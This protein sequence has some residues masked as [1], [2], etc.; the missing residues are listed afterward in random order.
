MITLFDDQ[1]TSIKRLRQSLRYFKHVVLQGETGSGKSVMAAYMIANSREKGLISLFI[2]PRKDLLHQMSETFNDFDIS[3]SFIAQGRDFNPFSKTF[4]CTIGTLVN[5]LDKVRPDIVFIDECHF[6]A[7]Q[8]EKVI[9]YY[10][11][12]GC[13]I[14]GLTASPEKSSGQGLDEYYGDMVVG[15]SIKELIKLK[16]LSDYKLF[17]P[18]TPDLS[19]IKTVA[20]DYA[21]GEISSF[22]EQESILIGNAVKHYSQHA[23]GKLNI[24][25]CTSIKH[26]HITADAFC[27]AGIPAMHIDGETPDVE[28]RRIARMFAQRELLVLCS[29]DLMT[30]GYDLAS[31]SGVRNV[32]IESMSDL[33][34]TK[35]RPLQRQ[36]NGR[37]LR[38]KDF[39]ATI[40]DH[41]GNNT[42]FGY[43]DDDISWS[44]KG[45][46]KGSY[47]TERPTPVKQCSNC[48][49]CHPPAPQCPNCGLVYPV[50]SRIVDEIEGTL[51][52]IDRDAMRVKQEK[53]D[54]SDLY[55]LIAIA[56][57]KGIA[58]PE[59]WA[60][61]IQS[62]NI[63][64][65]RNI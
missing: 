49:F 7:G 10:K 32:T 1:F 28:R 31:A 38:Y 54:R 3:H 5:R 29:V 43:P 59:R 6:G 36:K 27:K 15:P 30:F 2:V 23:M 45:R 42:R 65:R 21:R 55:A 8:L 53:K 37:V 12:L 48:F 33:R 24:A 35:S 13:W 50:K 18:Y 61:K 4:I 19:G 64:K 40:F 39:P 60:A 20:G 17:A 25:F 63:Q 57:K 14:I 41:S 26:S 22:M 16:R 46:E 62:Q 9:N 58:H 11:A 56:K 34:P 44:L 51:T 52:E 47:N